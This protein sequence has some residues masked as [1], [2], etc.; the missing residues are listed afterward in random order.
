LRFRLYIFDL[1]GTLIDTRQDITTAVNRMLEELGLPTKSLEE[2]V[3]YVG[4]GIRKLVERAVGKNSVDFEKAESLFRNYYQTHLV[5][6]TC[7]YPGVTDTLQM[8]ERSQK[9][10]LTNKA[11]RLSKAILDHLE[12]THFF[13][14][15]V[16]GDS[17][18]EKKPSPQGLEFILENT[19]VRPEDAVMIGDNKN[20]IITAQSTGVTSVYVTYGFTDLE[21]VLPLNPD[22]V[23]RSP[24]ELL[25]M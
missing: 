6:T 21:T 9:A 23:I 17:V 2:V 11:Y 13:S 16:G 7:P 8:L 3:S 15:I 19:G 22:F 25:T 18:R 10:V 4:D 24:G 5:D 1:D 20:D 12:I 14:V